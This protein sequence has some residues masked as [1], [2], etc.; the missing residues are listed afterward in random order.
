MRNEFMQTAAERQIEVSMDVLCVAG[1]LDALNAGD[2]HTHKHLIAQA[3]REAMPGCDVLL[4][5]QFSMACAKDAVQAISPVPVLSSPE[6]AV[7]LLK[8]AL[9]SSRP[10]LPASL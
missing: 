10:H 9:S 7:R 5:G 2:A 3:A 6:S 8:T 4:L 1:A